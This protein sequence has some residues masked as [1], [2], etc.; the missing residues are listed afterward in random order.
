MNDDADRHTQ[1]E[2]YL[3]RYA[4]TL[5]SFDAEAAADLWDIPG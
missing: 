5:T 1:V 2:E 4:E 3:T